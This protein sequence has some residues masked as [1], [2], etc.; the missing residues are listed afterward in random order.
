[1]LKTSPQDVVKKTETLISELKQISKEYEVLKNKMTAESVDEVVS[2][3]V[4]IKGVKV[5]VARFDQLDVEALRNVGDRLKAKIGN[6]VVVLAG[7][8]DEKVNLLVMATRDAVE[9]GIH[10]GNIIKEIAKITG[11]GGGGRPDMAQAGGKDVAKIN[12]ALNMAKEF[13][14]SLI[15]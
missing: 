11:G 13:I 8:K 3:V 9:K 15:K 2:K 14:E 12:Q 6:G 1:M 5:L 10:A 4:D 7:S